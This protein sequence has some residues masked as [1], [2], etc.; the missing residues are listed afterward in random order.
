MNCFNDLV[1]NLNDKEIIEKA[2]EMKKYKF[3]FHGNL[4]DRGLVKVIYL[5]LINI[6]T[7]VNQNGPMKKKI[8]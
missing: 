1:I 5:M 2:Y 8:R 3:N 7:L 4:E 6:H